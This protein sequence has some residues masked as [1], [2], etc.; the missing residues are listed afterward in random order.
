MVSI[1]EKTIGT[2]KTDVNA[3]PI[4]LELFL[5]KYEDMEDGYKYEWNHGLVER[6]T[7]INQEQTT[8]FLLLSRLFCNTQAFKEFGGLTAETDMMTSK[9]Q[10]R[11]P[12]IAF[13]SGAQIQKMKKGDNQIAQW[14]AEVISDTDNINR[15]EAKLEEYFK[16]GV[17]VVWHIFPVL[18]KVYV[19][20]AAD[21]VTICIGETIC[22]SVPVLPDFEISATDLFK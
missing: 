12:D 8:I 18:K 17:Q 3:G 7:K 13:Y 6:I 14:V 19:Y 10:L 2:K 9:N 22:S 16:A 4:S 5:E 11:R 1:T 15:V 20:T 21:K